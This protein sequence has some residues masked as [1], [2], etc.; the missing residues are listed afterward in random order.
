VTTQDKIAL[1]SAVGPTL[2]RYDIDVGAA[3]LAAR[4]SVTLPA[5]IHYVVA[6]TSRRFLYI[7]SSDSSA[8]AAN[9]VGTIHHLSAWRIDA[10]S[11]ALSPHGA[12]IALP[13]RP[14]HIT[15]DAASRHILVACNRPSLL[16]VYRLNDD[17]TLGDEVKQNE[18]VDAGI[19]AHQIRITADDRLAIL[20]TRGNDAAAGK[21][22]DP[23]SLR[24]FHYGNGQL[25]GE[26]S[27]A[28]NGGYGFGPRHLDFH[29]QAPWIYVSR[30]RENRLDVFRRTGDTVQAAAAYSVGTLA[31]PDKVRLRQA[32]GTVHVH[33][34]GRTVYVANRADATEAFQGQQ[35]FGGGENSLACYSIDAATGEPKLMGHTDTRGIHCRTFSIDPSGRLLVAAHILGRL[36]RDGDAL[37]E[38][39]AC[40]S[41]FR[42]GDDGRLAFVRTYDINAGDQHQFWMGIIR[43]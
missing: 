40:L 23:G 19:F 11:G 27:I 26:V 43:I 7:A 6:H 15:V 22:E 17:G 34:N 28:P 10:A 30:E 36:V 20:V 41:L 21:P 1:Y 18:A 9:I 39:P 2:T 33:P 8:G 38:V 5:N 31:A 16:L 37:R 24:V 3:T 35:V 32:A 4:E 29:P 13:T 25:T 12:R 42:I 14:I